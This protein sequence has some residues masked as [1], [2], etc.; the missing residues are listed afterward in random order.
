MNTT[1]KLSGDESS[2]DNVNPAETRVDRE[3]NGFFRREIPTNL[4]QP[5][6]LAA[7]DLRASRSTD[8]QSVDSQVTIATTSPSPPVSSQR[9]A[10]T[11]GWLSVSAATIATAAILGL[12]INRPFETI[13]PPQQA[14]S[15]DL[16]N[17]HSTDIVPLDSRNRPEETIPVSTSP[18]VD[19]ADSS[20]GNSGVTL[21]EVDSIDLRP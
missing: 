21:E 7:V 9:T 16:T 10:R 14:A 18:G 8:R 17:R 11:T 1:H 19:G 15:P 6:F 12:L 3:L 13:N 4:S 2:G 5:Q 20:L